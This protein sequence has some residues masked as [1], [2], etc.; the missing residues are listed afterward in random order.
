MTSGRAFGPGE[1]TPMDPLTWMGAGKF[2]D[3]HTR[4]TS[5]Q[6]HDS[7]ASREA[8]DSNNAREDQADTSASI[9]MLGSLAAEYHANAARLSDERATARLDAADDNDPERARRERLQRDVRRSIGLS[10]DDAHLDAIDD[11]DIDPERVRAERLRRQADYW[12]RSP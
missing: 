4:A 7:S 12:K 8:F 3:R 5:N 2:E 11:D 9:G 10:P 1:R 6:S